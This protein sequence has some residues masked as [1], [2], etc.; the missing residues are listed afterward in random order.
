MAAARPIAAKAAPTR[1]C[2]FPNAQTVPA[3][4]EN[5][6]KNL[7][8]GLHLSVSVRGLMLSLTQQDPF[9]AYTSHPL[10]QCFAAKATVP[11]SPTVLALSN[12]CSLFQAAVRYHWR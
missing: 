11:V 3:F 1:F 7:R 2:A 8:Q 12:A 6:Y 5:S 9:D 10:S 4:L